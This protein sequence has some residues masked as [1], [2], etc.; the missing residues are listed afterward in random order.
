MHEKVYERVMESAEAVQ[1]L[2]GARPRVGLVLG[3]GLG[4]FAEG[5]QEAI[6]VDYGELPHFP[7]SAVAGHAGRLVLGKARGVPV[8]VMAGRVHGYEGWT[9]DELA[10]GVR[11][12]AAMG[13]QALVL[14]NAAGGIHPDLKPGD[15]MRITDHINL[16]GRSPLTGPNDERLG[17]RFP[18]M[19]TSYDPA[20]SDLLE[21]VAA[22]G[23]LALRRGVYACMPGPAYETPAEIRM[24]R[25]MGADAV[26]MSTAPEVLAARHMGVRCVGIS[27][28]TNLAAGI[29]TNPLSHAEVK[30]VADR[31]KDRFVDLLERYVPALDEVLEPK[32]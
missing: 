27:V 7:V 9:V 8:V 22:E 6:S 3:S 15:L 5:L 11:V 10:H 26:G 28:I 29:A 25:S 13:I 1:K 24:L 18:D 30:E 31:V 23:K 20:Y 32:A 2:G 19:S 21:S 4:A 14:T 16:S 17:P 12:M